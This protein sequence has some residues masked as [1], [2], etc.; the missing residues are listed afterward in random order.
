MR[1][2][3]N[4]VPPTSNDCDFYSLGNGSPAPVIAEGCGF[5]INRYSN[6]T[7][8]IFGNAVAA[9]DIRRRDDTITSG[10]VYD[11]LAR[12]WDSAGN[13]DDIAGLRFYLASNTSEAEIG[14]LYARTV[15]AG[16]MANRGYFGNG[17][18]WSDLAT[19]GDKGAGTINLSAGLY[20]QGGLVVDG[21]GGINFPAYTAA[22]IAALGNAVNTANKA[23]GKAVF[24]TTNGRIMIATGSTAA[25]SWKTADGATTVTPA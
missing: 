3:A 4:T 9:A 20:L 18:V 15:Q 6:G 5:T 11:L 8:D 24:D 19:G 12:G 14:R 22:A 10:T 17:I 25:S 1:V 2:V 16:T 23:A 21:A 7:S 13:L